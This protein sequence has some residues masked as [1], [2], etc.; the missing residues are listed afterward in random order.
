LERSVGGGEGKAYNVITGDAVG[1]APGAH[2]VGIV[3]GQDSDDVDTLGADLRELLDVLGN[4][5]GRA[6][7]GEGTCIERKSG[8]QQAGILAEKCAEAQRNWEKR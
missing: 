5:V 2:D 3:V 8:G 1:L 6:D 4:V 7:G